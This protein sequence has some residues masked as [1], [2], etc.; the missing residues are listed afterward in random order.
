MADEFGKDYEI[1]EPLQG[2]VVVI[3]SAGAYGQV[4]SSHY[5]ERPLFPPKI[6]RNNEK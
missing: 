2:D 4:M 3:K 6:V 5:N 1:A